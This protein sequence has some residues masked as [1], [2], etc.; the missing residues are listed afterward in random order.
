MPLYVMF[1]SAVLCKCGSFKTKL[2]NSKIKKKIK[3]FTFQIW[4]SKPQSYFKNGCERLKLERKESLFIKY[5]GCSYDKQYALPAKVIE[6]NEP[7]KQKPGKS[8]AT[9][10][11]K[12]TFKCF[13]GINLQREEVCQKTLLNI[14]VIM[15]RQIQTLQGKIKAGVL[16]QIDL[17]GKPKNRP[18]AIGDENRQSICNHT[19]S[20]PKQPSHYSRSKSET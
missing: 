7:K 8:D 19:A 2:V 17:T 4:V 11:R 16:V 6:I 1:Y 20:F 18:H 3:L 15:Y 9:S 10:R 12:C 13:L 14:F 5:Y